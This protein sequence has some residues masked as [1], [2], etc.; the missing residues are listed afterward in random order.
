MATHG[1]TSEAASVVMEAAMEAWAACKPDG[2]VLSE[3]SIP[4]LLPNI[5]IAV[6]GG[7]ESPESSRR[8]N[9]LFNSKSKAL[10]VFHQMLKPCAGQVHFMYFWQAFG[11]ASKIVQ[12]GGAASSTAEPQSPS[13]ELERLR[14]RILQRFEAS[15]PSN[16]AEEP[17][18]ERI[19][20]LDVLAEVRSS[21]SSNQSFWNDV[22]ETADALEL[23]E[24]LNLEEMSAMMLSWLHDAR[25]WRVAQEEADSATSQPARTLLGLRK[26]SKDS[27]EVGLPVY[28]HIYD[29]SQDGNVQ[30]VNRVLAH[31]KSPLKFGGVFHAGVEVNGL[32]WCYGFCEGTSATGVCCV[33]PKLHPAHHYRQ[34]LRLKRTKLTAEEVMEIVGVLIEEYPGDDYD[35]LRRNC[36]HFAD[37]F[38]QRI[39][40]GHIPGWVHRL[41]RLGARLDGVVQV[42]SGL[43]DRFR[44]TLFKEE[45][46]SEDEEMDEEVKTMLKGYAEHGLR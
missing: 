3:D 40:V 21:A 18:T 33:E 30:K 15:S 39:G 1:E 29:V 6:P 19:R 7:L 38:C 43:H 31:R 17:G 23:V 46:T 9:L 32:E 22:L 4:S 2:M 14:D 20:T 34:T 44:G 12:A 8:L 25:E 27:I 11:E 36:C 42:A 13:A 24:D 5:A 35:I 10:P 37:D 45:K 41:A 28:L 16:R 26:P